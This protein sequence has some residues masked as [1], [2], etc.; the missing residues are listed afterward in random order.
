MLTHRLTRI[1]LRRFCAKVNP[2]QLPAAQ[3][4]EFLQEVVGG[5]RGIPRAGL[6]QALIGNHMTKFYLR[7]ACPG[8]FDSVDEDVP[9]GARAGLELIAA[10]PTSDEFMT[11]L[12]QCAEKKFFDEFKKSV[13]TLTGEKFVWK[14]DRLK[15]ARLDTLHSIIGAQRGDSLKGKQFLSL[16]GQHFIVSPEFAEA[17]KIADIRQRASKCLPFLFADGAL[18]RARVL[19]T[20]DQTVTMPS[21]NEAGELVDG[22][23]IPQKDV[24]HIVTLEI[25][26]T[27][28]IGKKQMMASETILELTED[29][30]SAGSWRVVDVNFSVS[31]NY[32]LDPAGL[33]EE[34]PET[35]DEDENKKP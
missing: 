26:L 6:F 13:Y 2:P 14:L 3:A 33:V 16:M 34:T 10:S 12:N 29:P 22:K 28:R 18:V 15:S 1:S 20:V 11:V 4:I 17:I 24:E 8:F 21:L 35:K 23:P 19:L 5:A 7:T 31:D 27:P 30:L 25:S 32:P 9:K